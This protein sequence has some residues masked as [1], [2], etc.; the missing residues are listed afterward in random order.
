MGLL[1][2][3][4]GA[5]TAPVAPTTLT[6]AGGSAQTATEKVIKLKNVD[7]RRMLRQK[8]PKLN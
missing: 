6:S 1:H 7:L 8:Q 3:G 4:S 2:V 5:L